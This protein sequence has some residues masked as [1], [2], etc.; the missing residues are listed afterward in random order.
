MLKW[1]LQQHQW[2]KGVHGAA[3]MQ[4]KH[5]S[6]GPTL[7]SSL[8]RAAASWSNG[9]IAQWEAGLGAWGCLSCSVKDAASCSTKPL[10]SPRLS[11]HKAQVWVTSWGVLPW[12][13]HCV[14]ERCSWCVLTSYPLSKRQAERAVVYLSREK[15]MTHI[16]TE[17]NV[18]SSLIATVLS[19]VWNLLWQNV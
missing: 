15:S 9:R 1:A 3:C 17:R 14:N 7:Q 19:T 6:H 13:P 18:I 4:L 11:L 12:D 5:C 10:P 16:S 8:P 2:E